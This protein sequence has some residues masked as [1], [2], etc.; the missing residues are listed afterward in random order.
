MS[1]HCT[2]CT[3]NR[4]GHSLHR[5]YSPPTVGANVLQIQTVH[6]QLTIPSKI[7][8]HMREKGAVVGPDT[9][10]AQTLNFCC[11]AVGLDRQVGSGKAGD[12]EW[13]GGRR[14]VGCRS[15]MQK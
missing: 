1:I 7:D 3:Y 6:D 4:D 8:R 14:R 10:L 2:H 12:A 9:F 13:E 5:L 11:A 15:Y